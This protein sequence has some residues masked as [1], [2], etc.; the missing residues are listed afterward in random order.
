MKEYVVSVLTATLIAAV[1]EKL[2]P[3]GEGGRMAAHV[4]FV[5]ALFLIV[6]LLSPLTAAV[7]YV[8]NLPGDGGISEWL[9]PSANPDYSQAFESTLISVSREEGMAWVVNILNS[10]FGIPP[11]CCEVWVECVSDGETVGFQEVRISL[12]GDCILENPHPIEA[13]VSE[14]LGCPCFVTVTVT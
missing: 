12:K 10:R 3:A 5:T 4:R 13:Y 9:T 2:S 6:S 8:R 11:E 7:E 1:T 14:S